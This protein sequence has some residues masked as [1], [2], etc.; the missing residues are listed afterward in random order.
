MPQLQVSP[1]AIVFTSESK[2]TCAEL[3][4]RYRPTEDTAS[5]EEPAAQSNGKGK[6]RAATV[7]EED[8][9]EMEYA[10]GQ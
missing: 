10:P 2:L 7:G 9:E 1:A 8:E 4:K 5:V 6:G 3:L